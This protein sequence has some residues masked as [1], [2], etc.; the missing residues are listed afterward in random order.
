MTVYV[1]NFYD[2][3]KNVEVPGV[4]SNIWEY[5]H[6]QYDNPVYADGSGSCFRGKNG[7]TAVLTDNST[8]SKTHQLVLIDTPSDVLRGLEEIVKNESPNFNIVNI[9][10]QSISKKKK[11]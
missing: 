11:H 6:K 4:Y 8:T 1:I 7:E 10:S 2:D 3:T 5:L 9:S